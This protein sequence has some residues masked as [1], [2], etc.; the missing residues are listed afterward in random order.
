MKETIIAS[1]DTECG[2]LRR[3]NKILGRWLQIMQNHRLP[4]KIKTKYVWLKARKLMKGWSVK[5][6]CQKENLKIKIP[7]I[8]WSRPGDWR[9]KVVILIGRR[10]IRATATTLWEGNVRRT[11]SKFLYSAA[12]KYSSKLKENVLKNTCKM[13]TLCLAYF[14]NS[15][16]I[17][18]IFILKRKCA[19]M[20][21]PSTNRITDH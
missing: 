21:K 16:T 11:N 9:R 8:E 15:L 13:T 3:V 5:L 10:E 7:C 20:F 1:L 4:N 6:H 14:F 18:T 19:N 12:A 2:C 17:K